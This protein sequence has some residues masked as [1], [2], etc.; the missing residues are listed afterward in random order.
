MRPIKFRAWDEK[1]K[2]MHTNFQ[3]IESGTEGNDW[4]LFVSDQRPIQSDNNLTNPYFSQQL[5]KMQFTGL[6]DKNGK[7]IYERDVLKN[8]I[9]ATGI[10]QWYKDGYEIRMSEKMYSR[11]HTFG[12][13]EVIGNIYENPDLC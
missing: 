3:W 7:E 9:G 6:L 2:I 1:K 12:E 13:H 4:I 5:K 11:F 8:E 10:V